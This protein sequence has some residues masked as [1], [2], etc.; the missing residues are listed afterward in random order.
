[1]LDE[2]RQVEKHA[3]VR[4]G[5][6]ERDFRGVRVAW[7]YR[8]PGALDAD[9]PLDSYPGQAAAWLPKADHS[10][11]A[12]F[13]ADPSV[14]RL[15][16]FRA[17]KADG[18]NPY[19]TPGAASPWKDLAGGHD[20]QL[21]NFN[22]TPASG[23]KGDGSVLSPRRLEYGAQGEAA[24]VADGVPDLQSLSP[25]SADLWFRTGWDGPTTRWEYLLDWRQS[26]GD[27]GMT[28]ALYNGQVR[29]FLNGW[30]DVAPIQPASWYHLVVAKEPGQVRVYLNGARVYTGAQPNMGVQA[31][32]IHIGGPEG[33][34]AGLGGPTSAADCFRGAMAQVGIWYGAM[35]DAKALAAFGADKA[36]YLP[37]PSQPKEKIIALRADKADG[38]H[39]YPA[40]GATSPWVDLAG[41]RT[42]AQLQ[43]FNG[44][45]ASGWQGTGTTSSPYRLQFD[46][47]DD[48]VTIAAGSVGE[49]EVAREITTELWFRPGVVPAGQC[50]YL[51][52]WLQGFQRTRGM[53]VALTGDQL[54]L[55]L[56]DLGWVALAPVRPARWYNLVVVQAPG[57]VTAYLNGKKIYT[58]S[59]VSYGEPT[60]EI[61]LGASTSLGPSQY[62][63]FFNGALAQFGLRS[64]SLTNF[65]VAVAYKSN[66]GLYNAGGPPASASLDLELDP[67]G[68]DDGPHVLSLSGFNPNPAVS[69]R[70]MLSF[71]LATG[72]PATVEMIDVTGRRVAS[73]DVGSLG[74]GSHTIQVGRGMNLPTGVYMVRLQQG[75]RVLRAKAAV[76]N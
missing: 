55:K 7:W 17:D 29:V 15:L 62:S 36:L 21:Q 6:L 18:T 57:Q 50:Q 19:P 5:E 64:G 37:A 14:T 33:T 25:V 38:A 51:V 49:H 56:D 2:A 20:A 8:R 70:L 67:T 11:E 65:E 32:P 28:V 43:N 75:G 40:P 22:G 42:D 3:V 63:Q 9:S 34:A 69:S 47:V 53:N 45:T 27:A 23:W 41:A 24:A 31:T 58:G 10:I 66:A 74:P 68:L 39:A 44:T 35:D 12:S 48:A 46:G 16:W 52:Q 76:V 59:V 4:L 30:V 72:E 54:Q 73:E 13:A 61:V 60:T 26:G 71:S 1:M